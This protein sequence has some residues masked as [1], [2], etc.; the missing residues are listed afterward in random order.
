MEDSGTIKCTHGGIRVQAVK[1]AEEIEEWSKCRY[2]RKRESQSL[3]KHSE[4][5]LQYIK[6]D[7]EKFFPHYTSRDI[8]HKS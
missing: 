6:T 8:G 7:N 1:A 3:L 4:H 5:S 2:V